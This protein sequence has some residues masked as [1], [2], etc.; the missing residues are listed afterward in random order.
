MFFVVFEEGF[1]RVWA[2]HRVRSRPDCQTV[3]NGHK[4]QAIR[5]QGFF[6]VW[7]LIAAFV[8]LS[9]SPLPAQTNH[10]QR[11]RRSQNAAS[12]AQG[13]SSAESASSARSPLLGLSLTPLELDVP[14]PCPPFRT[15]ALGSERSQASPAVGNLCRPTCQPCARQPKPPPSSWL[16]SRAPDPHRVHRRPHHPP[17]TETLMGRRHH[18]GEGEQLAVHGR[19]KTRN[20]Q[21][22]A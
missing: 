14:C 20:I 3:G 12:R 18:G 10:P 15:L 22:H 13:A 6:R 11:L 1:F 4:S 2:R 5:Q 9:C 19:N 16:P 21:H 8:V 7:D 17:P